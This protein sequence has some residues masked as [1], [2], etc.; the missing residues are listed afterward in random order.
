LIRD[1]CSLFQVMYARPVGLYGCKPWPS[2]SAHS[3]RH[4]PRDPGCHLDPKGES[5]WK[6]EASG[7][8]DQPLVGRSAAESGVVC[9]VI[10]GTCMVAGA[11]APAGG[12]VHRLGPSYDH[13]LEML[14]H[15]CM[16]EQSAC[17]RQR[18]H[19]ERR[20]AGSADINRGL[21]RLPALAVQRFTR[22]VASA[23]RACARARA[24]VT[25]AEQAPRPGFG[26]QR[27]L[28]VRGGG[29]ARHI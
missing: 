15:A 22:R 14:D 9:T 29:S 20:A 26:S 24:R 12:G 4:I 13:A 17:A 2:S 7:R 11:R 16:M 3:S 28:R 19:A 25:L 10:A 18:E 27:V 5:V 8:A 6:N 1:A 23:S 21:C